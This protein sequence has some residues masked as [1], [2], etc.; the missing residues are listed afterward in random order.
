MHHTNQQ[1]SPLP[2]EGDIVLT[3]HPNVD[4][5]E[6]FPAIPIKPE[7]YYGDGPFDPPSS[8]EEEEEL[9]LKRTRGPVDGRAARDIEGVG[10]MKFRGR[11]VSS[12]HT[13]LL[14]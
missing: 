12:D 9:L 14:W 11:K 10:G 6:N 2:Q 4:L 13:V 7:V 8:D 3:A 5:S 1:Y